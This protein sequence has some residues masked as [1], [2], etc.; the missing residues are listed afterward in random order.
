MNCFICL[1]IEIF[2]IFG[3]LVRFCW[4][5]IGM[6]FFIIFLLK[7]IFVYV[8]IVVFLLWIWIGMLIYKKINL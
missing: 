5:V 2:W 3:I 6:V 4:L 1:G 7:F 8:I